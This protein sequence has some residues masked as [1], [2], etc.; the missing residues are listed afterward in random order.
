MVN[1]ELIDADLF[2]DTLLL[3]SSE[4]I[5]NKFNK[6]EQVDLVEVD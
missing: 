2:T 1:Y 6:I 4:K 5:S 3:T